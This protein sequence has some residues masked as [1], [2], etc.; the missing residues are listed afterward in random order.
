MVHVLSNGGTLSFV[1]VCTEYKKI[2]GRLLDVK[3]LVLDSAPGDSSV[4]RGFAAMSTGFPKNYLW[5]PAAAFTFLLLG[6]LA[7]ANTV[8][9]MRTIV[10]TARESLNDWELVDR[11]TR[12][13]YVY[14]T[15]DE[16]VGFETVD[17]HVKKSEEMGVEVRRL[18]EEE[19]GHVIHML[20]DGER[21]WK[22]V[23]DLWA[24]VE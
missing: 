18:R 7:I 8:F 14:S 2:T 22:S 17:E 11:E 24:D 21:Y 5:Y 13:L 12:R 15:N 10:D 23:R 3:A 16:I 4:R 19:T 1:D 6:S 9:G 20:K